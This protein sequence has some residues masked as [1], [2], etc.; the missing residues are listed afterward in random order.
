MIIKLAVDFSGLEGHFKHVWEEPKKA[1]TV[2]KKTFKNT[3]KKF[4]PR[5][6]GGAALAGIGLSLAHSLLKKKD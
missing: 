4:G 2:V 5:V 1:S 6:V 3:V